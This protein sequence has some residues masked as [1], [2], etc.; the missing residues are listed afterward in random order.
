MLSYVVLTRT[1]G[2]S[3]SF[4]EMCVFLIPK[5]QSSNSGDQINGLKTLSAAGIAL[6][7]GRTK[8]NPRP[9]RG[10]KRELPVSSKRSCCTCASDKTSV[11]KYDDFYTYV[12][13][14]NVNGEQVNAQPE[15]ASLSHNFWRAASSSAPMSI[16]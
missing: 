16:Q 11:K 13:I 4:S 15:A 6:N 2:S 10:L 9:S 7:E 3:Y 12:K 8:F 14:V 5:V 1:P